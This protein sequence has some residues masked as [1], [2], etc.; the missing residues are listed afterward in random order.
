MTLESAP[1]LNRVFEHL[2][3]NSSSSSINTDQLIQSIDLTLLKENSTDDE[4]SQLNHLA[5][6]NQVAAV[7][8]FAQHLHHFN[9]AARFNLAT[10]VNFPA[11]TDDVVTCLEDIDQ[12][13]T[14]GV[15][16][17]D[18]VLP[19]QMYLRDNKQQAL[20]QCHVIAEHCKK[21]GLILKIILETGAFPEIQSIYQVSTELLTIGCDFLKTSTGK[22]TQGASLSAAFAMLSAIKASGKRCGVKISGGIKTPQQAQSYAYLAELMMGKKINKDWFRIGASSLIYELL[23]F[24]QKT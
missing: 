3:I 14:L 12:A 10:V 17:I 20:N 21:H 5:Q 11:G 2:T 22:M 23:D 24:E 9:P 4:L 13:V 8:V 7:C 1:H 15:K 19:Y 16:E 18:Y 6:T